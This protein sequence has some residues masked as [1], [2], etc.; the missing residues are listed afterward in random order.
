M[1]HMIVENGVPRVGDCSGT[2]A[3]IGRTVGGPIERVVEYS[4]RTREH[5]QLTVYCNR[6]SRA[7]GM[8]ANVFTD[9]DEMVLFGPVVI[10][11][12]SNGK[13][14]GLT[15]DEIAQVSIVQRREIPLPVLAVSADDGTVFLT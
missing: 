3:D 1:K 6:A 13:L 11:G 12:T 4:S 15:A 9:M 10:I 5:V 2:L 7:N 8:E 14:V